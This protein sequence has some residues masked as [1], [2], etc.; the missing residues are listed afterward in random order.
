MVQFYILIILVNFRTVLLLC[1]NQNDWYNQK[2]FFVELFE[3]SL[4]EVTACGYYHP[5][6]TSLVRI[7]SNSGI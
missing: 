6:L 1:K 7:A 2:C 4:L 3:L 5:M